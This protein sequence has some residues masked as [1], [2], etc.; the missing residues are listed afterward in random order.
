MNLSYD[1]SGYRNLLRMSDENR[2]LVEGKRDKQFFK[3]LLDEFCT[4]DITIDNADI[5][6]DF[7]RPVG[8]REKV[9]L[10]CQSVKDKSYSDRLVGFVDREFRK[11]ELGE[12]IEDKLS[13]HKIENRLVWSRGHSI[14]NYLFDFSIL[15]HPLRDLSATD[16]FDEAL[17]LFEK[18]IESTVRKACAASLAA[19]E[20]EKLKLIATSFNWKLLEVLNSQVILSLEL[21]K[22]ELTKKNLPLGETEKIINRYQYWS[23]KIETVDFNLAKWLCHGHIGISFIWATYSRCVYDVC[24]HKGVAK[25]ETEVAGIQRIKE[26]NRFHAC[27]SWCARQARKHQCDYPLEVLQLLDVTVSH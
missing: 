16:C 18:I 27:A 14:E 8:N 25:P 13:T 4:Q 23:Q 1:P 6:I 2:L 22:Q 9:E 17:A 19:K 24:I 7:D 3:L 12:T 11:F 10:I 5:L 15:R 21:W 20:L 26:N